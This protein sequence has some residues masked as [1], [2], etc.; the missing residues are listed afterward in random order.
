MSILKILQRT[1]FKI[2]AGY[3]LGHSPLPAVEVPL[4]EAMTVYIPLG[5]WS[6]ID[7]PFEI[8]GIMQTSFMY[9]T[10]DTNGKGSAP[11]R[12]DA[13]PPPGSG[14]I[15]LKAPLGNG[16]IAGTEPLQE[17][18]GQTPIHISKGVNLLSFFPR[19]DGS[20]ELVVMGH[21]GYPIMLR[22]V[23]DGKQ[24][25]KLY[26]FFDPR[27][28][29]KE[30]VERFESDDHEKVIS[31]LVTHLYHNTT[32]YG[33]T[34]VNKKMEYRYEGLEYRLV[35]QIVGKRYIGE[36]WLIT[37]PAGAQKTFYLYNQLF[38]QEGIYSATLVADTLSPG[39]TTAPGNMVIV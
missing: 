19:F 20:M 12:Y 34:S 17:D 21:K 10:P 33:Y 11:K 35:R 1:V 6:V 15:A 22:L 39:K 9:E 27:L 36:E 29:Q 4:Q 28:R 7:F 31:R 3:F 2:V 25:E 32:P 5:E 37:N 18:S 16:T 23:V 30:T 14:K 8:K 26:T 38:L 24:G 13:P